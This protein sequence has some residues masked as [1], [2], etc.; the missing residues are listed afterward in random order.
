[1]DDA[2][3]EQLNR[4]LLEA[5]ACAAASG[6][7]GRALRQDSVSNVWRNLL[8]GA[9]LAMVVMYGF[10]RSGSATLV[11]MIG[12][13]ICTVAAFIGLMLFGRT[14]N[15]ISLAGV[16]FA[17][18][19]T[20]D[21]TIVVLE[22]IEQARRR[23][24]DRLRAA[25]EGTREVWSAVLACTATTVLVFA[26]ILFVREEAGQLYSDIAIAISAAIIASMLVAITVVPTAIAR[27]GFSGTQNRQV[28]GRGMH[29]GMLRG[30]SWLIERPLRRHLCLLLSV[31]GLVWIVVWLT[32]PAEYLPEGEEPKA[33]TR[34]IP[35][36]GYNLAEMAMVADDVRAKPR[37]HIGADPAGFDRGE[38]DMPPLRYFTMNVSSGGSVHGVRTGAYRRHGSD[39]AR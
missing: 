16:A 4:E 36:P 19:M 14:I 29:E 26:P 17:I 30:I 15:V 35:P 23:G 20:L 28:S 11:S 5:T 22:S 25:I 27:L 9:L 31:L 12:I 10:L 33:F 24:L 38:T 1:M 3:V 7:R 39:D 18:G 13:P 6:Q 32:P 21:N 8:L 37:A 2:V 34:M